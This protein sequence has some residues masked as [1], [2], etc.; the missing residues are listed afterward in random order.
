MKN[1]SEGTNLE[2]SRILLEII[3]L[4]FFRSVLFGSTLYYW[5]FQSLV[6]GYPNSLSVG[7]LSWS[8]PQV[9]L[10]IGWPLRQILYHYSPSTDE[11]AR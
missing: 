5:A 11:E 10:D 6:P 9:K 3:F 4:I 2:Y 8:R 7:F 1:S